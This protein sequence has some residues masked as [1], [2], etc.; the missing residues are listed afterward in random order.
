[1]T[2][3]NA[4]V[5]NKVNRVDSDMPP[6]GASK[7]R[8]RLAIVSSRGPSDINQEPRRQH[9]QHEPVSAR[10][11]IVEQYAIAAARSTNAAAK[12]TPPNRDIW[13]LC[14]W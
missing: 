10:D 13:D 1:M 11:D 14:V 2:T 7:S 4:K 8:A 5:M 12:A 6:V 9:D 3:V